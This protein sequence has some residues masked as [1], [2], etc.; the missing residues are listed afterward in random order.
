MWKA[1][2]DM[3][4]LP[5]GEVHLWKMNLGE[6][7]PL[8]PVLKTLLSADEQARAG[9][10][11]FQTD[12]Q[13]FVLGRSVL[14]LLLG[15]Y[16]KQHPS[17]IRFDYNEFGKPFLRS[18]WKK[19]TVQFNLSHSGEVV[20]LG[21]TRAGAIGVD[22]EKIDRKHSGLDIA[23]RF[24]SRNEYEKLERLEG[25][26]QVEAFFKCW[27]RKEAFIK[28]HGKG[29]SI[30]LNWFDVA[31]LPEEPPQILSMKEELGCLSDWRLIHVEPQQAYLGA[32][33]V[34]QPNA[35]MAW[36]QVTRNLV[37]KLCRR[38]ELPVGHLFKAGSSS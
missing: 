15:A 27:T 5:P 13:R 37:E 28:A 6:M 31:V 19:T 32:A 14:R 21:F 38:F 9:R 1:T 8:F 18:K 30:P 33:V 3:D 29:L 16:L 2:E 4:L 22:V 34:Q 25:P 35:A 11:Y 26:L 36:Y 7:Q 24:F 12:R 23:K 20:L 10:F 17:S